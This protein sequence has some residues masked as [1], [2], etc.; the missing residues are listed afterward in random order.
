MLNILLGQYNLL[1]GKT[2]LGIPDPKYTTVN[3]QEFEALFQLI[4]HYEF[5]G[6]RCNQ[7]KS[8][9]LEDIRT[10]THLLSSLRQEVPNLDKQEDS[11][12]ARL[13]FQ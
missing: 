12:K 3:Y 8:T 5:W 11:I 10:K 9:L 2:D 6:K 1:P 7:S 4:K 13:S